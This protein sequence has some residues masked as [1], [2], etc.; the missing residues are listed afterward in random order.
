MTGRGDPR[1]AGFATPWPLR[2]NP[3]VAEAREA[4]LGWLGAFGL[5]RDEDA[6]A[7]FTE[8]RLAEAAGWLYPFAGP[9][10][11]ATAA[12]MLG[13]CLL[14]S[15]GRPDRVA[16]GDPRRT[17]EI[18]GALIGIVHGEPVPAARRSPAV[19]A[20][21]DLWGRMAGGMSPRL[22]GRLRHHWAGYFSA[23]ATAAADHATGYAHADLDAYLAFRADTVC[24]YGQLD[25][26][27]QWGGA[28][29]PA[30]LWHHPALARVRR[31]GADLAA[32]ASDTA[33]PARARGGDG[34][35][36]R[37][38]PPDVVRVVAATRHCTRPEAVRHASVLARRKVAELVALEE[39]AL[40]RLLSGL[41]ER[42][43]DAVLGYPQLV[44]HRV[45]AARAWGR[46]S[47]PGV[48][49]AQPAPPPSG[50]P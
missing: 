29:V 20:F 50:A 43:R 18:A 38:G 39:R 33:E 25:L 11:S 32:V 15:G 19:T 44:H 35:G 12:Q 8:L 22:R 41:D 16:G 7:D 49:A 21:A 26:A 13:W 42:H 30:Q 2:H 1:G 17:A 3:H 37:G 6:A 10:D 40:P 23:R 48:R 24:A 45:V 36:D 28:E 34:R 31:L 4:A 14:P 5:L 9:E 47:H 46:V 27:E